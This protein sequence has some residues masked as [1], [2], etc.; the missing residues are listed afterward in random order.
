MSV[1]LTGVSSGWRESPAQH[2][3]V[4]CL[5]SGPCRR[6]AGP[7]PPSTHC[8]QPRAALSLTFWQVPP[9]PGSGKLDP[10]AD[11]GRFSRAPHPDG[12]PR[13]QEMLAVTKCASAWRGG[14]LTGI[15]QVTASTDHTYTSWEK[16]LQS[17]RHGHILHGGQ[18]CLLHHYGTATR[19]KA[20]VSWGP[21]QCCFCG[22]PRRCARTGRE[23]LYLQPPARGPLRGPAC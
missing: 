4:R 16:R 2:S 12:A 1:W 18:P 9:C 23:H 22:R 8:A 5:P 11:P 20:Q 17:S 3:A 15:S 14:P 7:R 19:V 10:R 21:K 13:G 6:R